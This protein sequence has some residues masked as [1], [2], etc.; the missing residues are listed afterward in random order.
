MKIGMVYPQ[1][2]TGGDPGAVRALGDAAADLG[3]DYLL[4]YDHVVGAEHADRE[5]KLWGPYT[6][7]DPFHDPFVLFSYLAGRHESLEFATGVIILPQ[8]QTVLVAKQAAD[9]DLLSGERLRLGVG[10]GWNWVEYDALGQDFSTRGK[11]ANEQIEFMR[12]LWSEPLVDWKGEFD[13][14][15]RGNV[16]PRPNR[17]IPIWIGGFSDPAFRR[18]VRLGDGFMFAGEGERVFP[19]YDRLLE[20]ASEEGRDLSG[21]GLEYV[22]TRGG[23]LDTI[24][25][26]REQW[27]TLGGTHFSVS[28]MERGFATMDDHIAFF[29]RFITA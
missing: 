14:I 23:E 20:L 10:V 9:L 16:L 17:Q 12:T 4:A 2:E 13:M 1:I 21:F 26:E 25:E 19:A 15:E 24:I 11:R 8:R 5:P 27:R 28:S 18:G 6:E 7:N 3:F 22:K 29:E